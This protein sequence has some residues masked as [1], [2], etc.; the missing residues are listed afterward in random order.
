MS[1][2]VDG[3]MNYPSCKCGHDCEMPCWQLV[4]LSD[5]PCGVC[6]CEPFVYKPAVISV[7]AGHEPP[8]GYQLMEGAPR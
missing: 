6:G 7:P 5:E 4:G 3:N 1:V 2:I 8:E